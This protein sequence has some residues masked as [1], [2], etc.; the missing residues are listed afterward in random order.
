MVEWTNWTNE[1][2]YDLSIIILELVPIILTKNRN[3]NKWS[4][5]F[6]GAIFCLVS[7]FTEDD[8]EAIRRLKEELEA[9]APQIWHPVPL[10][11]GDKE[12]FFCLIWENL[13]MKSWTKRYSASWVEYWSDGEISEALGQA[14]T[15]KSEGEDKSWKTYWRK[16]RRKFQAE[17]KQSHHVSA[18]MTAKRMAAVF[19]AWKQLRMKWLN[20]RKILMLRERRQWDLLCICWYSKNA[21]E[22]FPDPLFGIYDFLLLFFFPLPSLWTWAIGWSK[23]AT[24][25]SGNLKIKLRWSW[26]WMD[27]LNAIS[28]QGHQEGDRH[29]DQRGQPKVLF[30]GKCLQL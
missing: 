19:G 23:W 11:D 22:D 24:T 7:N 17:T 8:S 29:G 2:F 16:P 12:L 13:I 1:L 25:P 26:D 28:I 27:F 30:C 18:E 21:S 9:R 15:R 5:T 3:N 10:C 6:F 14:A 20:C 4:F